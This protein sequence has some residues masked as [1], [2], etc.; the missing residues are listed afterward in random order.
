MAGKN[1]VEDQPKENET[2][3]PDAVSVEE[4]Q[5]QLADLQAANEALKDDLNYC[6][7][8]N[9]NLANGSHE[10]KIANEALVAEKEFLESKIAEYAEEIKT[11]KAGSAAPSSSLAIG[12]E[13]KE[14]PQLCD[15]AV[16]VSYTE[17]GQERKGKF[18]LLV[19]S[20][21]HNGENLTAEQAIAKPEVMRSLVEGTIVKGK[22]VFVQEIFE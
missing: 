11:L 6:K 9:E 2:P 12:K 1:K 16:D 7:E 5:A 13:K 4:L 17:E 19:A 20:L 15:T 22:S 8:A 10:L 18:K 3:S 14:K 21:V